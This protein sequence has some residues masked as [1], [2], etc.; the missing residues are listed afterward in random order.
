MLSNGKSKHPLT[1]QVRQVSEFSSSASIFLYLL[2][3]LPL[4]KSSRD[5]LPDFMFTCQRPER[6][7]HREGGSS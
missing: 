2:P 3:T 1:R 7:V 5:T 4:P 6:L